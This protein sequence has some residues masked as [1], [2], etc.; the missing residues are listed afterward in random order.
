MGMCGARAVPGIDSRLEGPWLLGKP[1]AADEHGRFL[2]LLTPCPNRPAASRSVASPTPPL[3]AG[4]A[5]CYRY[6]KNKPFI[7]SRYC[8]GVP[9][10]QKAEQLRLFRLVHGLP[11]MPLPSG[12]RN[13]PCLFFL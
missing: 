9:G 1:L 7:K 4:P 10:E 6:C 12:T 3:A 5:R 11:V 8:R 2:R 13:L